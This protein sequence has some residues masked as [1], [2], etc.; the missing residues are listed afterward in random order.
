MLVVGKALG[1]LSTT[2]VRRDTM[3]LTCLDICDTDTKLLRA[4]RLHEGVSPP[5]CTA[6]D[7]Q[8]PERIYYDAVV[9]QPRDDGIL[10]SLYYRD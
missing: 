5:D 1:A 10:T 9:R 2:A 4:G 6:T 8:S 3:M 7:E